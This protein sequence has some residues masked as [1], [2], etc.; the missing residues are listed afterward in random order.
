M[1]KGRGVGDKGR[2]RLGE[3]L[4]VSGRGDVGVG[5]EGAGAGE[6]V[7]GDEWGGHI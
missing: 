7:T 4:V 2:G 1:A 3:V 6:G 5:D